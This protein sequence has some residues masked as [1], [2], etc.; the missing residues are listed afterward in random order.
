MFLAFCALIAPAMADT[1]VSAAAHPEDPIKPGGTAV[2]T[3]LFQSTWDG[4]NVR[5]G[6]TA[7]KVE[8]PNALMTKLDSFQWD[9][10]S[11]MPRNG[12]KTWAD[13]ATR[14]FVDRVGKEAR[15]ML[16]RIPADW[17]EVEEDRQAVLA[18]SVLNRNLDF[19]RPFPHYDR[20]PMG[21]DGSPPDKGFLYFGVMRE[22]CLDYIDSVE[23]LRW[24]RDSYTNSILRNSPVRKSCCIFPGNPLRFTMLAR[25]CEI[26]ASFR[27]PEAVNP[28]ERRRTTVLRKS[29]RWRFPS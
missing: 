29:I 18:V 22:K 20:T 12:F 8:P 19:A 4:M 5:F 2:W 9:A 11:V 16:P 7:S 25:R 6:G 1:M 3:P 28:P 27:R 26:F 17:L 23:V 14:G 21:F 10:R 24:S 15:D 13:I